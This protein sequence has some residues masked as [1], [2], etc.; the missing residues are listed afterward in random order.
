MLRS[1]QGV[2]NGKTLGVLSKYNN[3]KE[4]Y[5]FYCHNGT[6]TDSC[7]RLNRRLANEVIL[8]Q[9]AMVRFASIVEVG[10]KQ[11]PAGGITFDFGGQHRQRE[12]LSA[13]DYIDALAAV[14]EHITPQC[15]QTLELIAATLLNMKA[16][17]HSNEVVAVK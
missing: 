5:Q 2:P 11:S 15:W 6:K 4:L 13:A 10:Q 16:E 3:L 17:H 14:A 8:I 7:R 1:V 12:I 9:R